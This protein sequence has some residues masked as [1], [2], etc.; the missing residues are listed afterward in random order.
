[1]TQK[2]FNSLEEYFNYLSCTEDT[3]ETMLTWEDLL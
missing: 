2:D 3:E 1:M